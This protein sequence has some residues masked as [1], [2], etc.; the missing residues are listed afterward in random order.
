MD[1]QNPQ[2]PHEGLAGWERHG[3]DV[4]GLELAMLALVPLFHIRGGDNNHL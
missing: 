1:L 2:A 3:K 4:S